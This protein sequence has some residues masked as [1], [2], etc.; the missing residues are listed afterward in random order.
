MTQLSS[1]VISSYP[2]IFFF[3]GDKFFL[4][5]LALDMEAFFG[6]ILHLCI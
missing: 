1:F 2:R 5:L 4:L 3:G 6:S